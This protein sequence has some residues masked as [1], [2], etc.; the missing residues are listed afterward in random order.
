LANPE[1]LQ[2]LKQGVEA[3]NPWRRENESSLPDLR[4]ADLRGADFED[5]NLVAPIANADVVML[6]RRARLT[7]A[8][9]AGAH[10]LH[11]DRYIAALPPEEKKTFLDSEK[12]FLDSLSPAGLAT[13]NLT[14]QK[15][16]KFR[17]EA[18]P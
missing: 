10:K 8:H 14:Q 9:L 3:W 4:G 2:I 16:A 17:R 1:H 11:L 6:L 18:G 7:G 13:F 5:A 15:L 12:T